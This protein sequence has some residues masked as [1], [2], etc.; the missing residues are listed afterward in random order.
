MDTD[1]TLIEKSPILEDG[2]KW[3]SSAERVPDPEHHVVI[4]I[5]N[6]SKYYAMKEDH[7]VYAEDE[8]IGHY[9]NERWYIDPPYPR[10]D[11]SP[12]THNADVLEGSEVS[13]WAEPEPDE[14]IAYR[15]RFEPLG[16]YD[17]MS[18]KAGPN[19]LQLMYHGLIYAT[20]AF[21]R[22]YKL[23]E[24]GSDLVN[25]CY[26]MLCDMQSCLDMNIHFKNGHWVDNGDAVECLDIE[27]SGYMATP[28]GKYA[29][30]VYNS[31]IAASNKSGY[32]VHKVICL[33][34]NLVDTDLAMGREFGEN[35]VE[36]K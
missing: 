23:G 5:V 3:I 7:I 33:L 27:S 16:T 2:R 30:E 31:I 14:L 29:W 24:G 21:S 34:E 20:T 22:A 19:T 8:K 11:Y 35:G 6:R 13:H 28:E 26:G 36:N 1:K 10:F 17:Y 25:A 4:R 32:D 18:I 9:A 12:L 15:K